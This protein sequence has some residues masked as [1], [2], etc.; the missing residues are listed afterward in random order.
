MNTPCD[1]L[2][3]QAGELFEC[4]SQ[5]KYWRIRTPYLYPDGDRLDLFTKQ[6]DDIL[7]LT[8]LGETLRW[9]KMQTISMRR[10]AKQNALIED[11]CLNHGIEFYKGMLMARVRS[12]ND[13]SA[14]LTRLSQAAIRVADLWFTFRFRA[15]ESVTDEVAD[16]LN[17]KDVGYERSEKL[18]GRS[19]RVWNID[20]HTRLP[21]VSSLVCVLSTGSRAAAKRVSEHVVATWYDLSHMK[22]GPE[23]LKFISLFD[24][25][26]DV[27]STED[28]QLVDDL[29]EIARWS[30]PEEFIEL[31]QAA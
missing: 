8:D 24:D 27:W 18:P 20:F 31:L 4:N 12:E 9:L 15:V 7:T 3:K 26:M 11:I 17:E 2:I 25:T 6:D 13:F 23:Q 19:G 28:F 29:S 22:V 30:K 16:F 14:V 1:L 21:R 10:T 5:G